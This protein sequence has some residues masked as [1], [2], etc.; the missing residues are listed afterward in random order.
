M[1]SQN[2]YQSR[3]LTRYE[4]NCYDIKHPKCLFYIWETK[5]ICALDTP[6]R[7]GDSIDSVP[8][9][10]QSEM[11]ASK[12]E[13]CQI[14]WGYPAFLLANWR[15]IPCENKKDS[16][17]NFVEYLH[18][19]K[20]DR[21]EYEEIM[22]DWRRTLETFFKTSQ[23]KNFSSFFEVGRR[24][25][26]LFFASAE[27]FSLEKDVFNCESKIQ[28][29]GFD[30]PFY[31]YL[32][33]ACESAG[34]SLFPQLVF[35]PE[36]DRITAFQAA[37]GNAWAA[38]GYIATLIQYSICAYLNGVWENLD[39]TRLEVVNYWIHQLNDY[40]LPCI[41]PSAIDFKFPF[42]YIDLIK[43][44][45]DESVDYI[46]EAISKNPNYPPELSEGDNIYSYILWAEKTAFKVFVANQL[47]ASFTREQQDQL[48]T[49]FRRYLEYLSKTYGANED[50]MSRINMREY[51]HIEPLQISLTT[52]VQVTDKD[53]KDVTLERARTDGW[54]VPE[55]ETPNKKKNAKIYHSFASSIQNVD[56]E[57]F[58]TYLHKK[59][60][61]NGGK[62][63]ACILGAAIYKYHYLSR[64]P[65]ET[66][67]MA[68]FP[69]IS[70]TFKAIKH[71]LNMRN[72]QGTDSFTRAFMLIDISL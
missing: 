64:V 58:L 25:K 38:Y 26:M 7:K 20:L 14:A 12:D 43:K 51:G 18:A 35:V 66:E 65:S 63:V 28:M 8:N 69:K 56:A 24:I 60:D 48:Q 27:D 19:V 53:G 10:H 37:R 47:Y 67:F 49:F 36:Y 72:E 9:V 40:T 70:S 4:P 62:E 3:L 52:H 34:D 6:Y 13:N 68:E 44:Y 11:E 30:K 57:K 22:N 54:V 29:I 41:K 17:N 45:L 15:H 42:P 32:V 33:P 21:I 23:K 39:F 55:T 16:Y 59:I 61:G 71:Q 31:A 1:D 5:C 2:L 46:R 50:F